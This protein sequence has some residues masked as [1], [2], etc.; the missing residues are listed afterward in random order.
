LIT[1]LIALACFCA[2]S[3]AKEDSTL[4]RLA[5]NVYAHVVSPDGN[6]V[7]NAG[8]LVLEH[9]VLVFDTH[10]TPEAGQALL[11]AIRSI[12]PKPVRY[13][14]N[15]HAHADH[16]HGNQAF[17]DAQLIGSIAARRD[18]MELDLPSMNRTLVIAQRQL[19]A[20]R[21]DLGTEQDPAQTG[22][23]R[24]QIK[25]RED[26][27]QTMSRLKIMPPVVTTG[28][29]IKIIDGRKEVRLLFLGKGHTDGDLV[30]FL[31]A[32]KIAF[33][34]DLFFNDAI[35]NVQD[36][37]ILEWIRTLEGIL[38]LE[39]DQFVPGHG[40]I[41]ARKDV[42]KFQAYFRDLQALVQSAVDRGDT[43]EQA[44]RDLTTP[45]KYSSH[46][47]QN[48]FPSNVQKMY[49]ELKALQLSKM[50]AKPPQKSGMNP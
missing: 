17:A 22:K 1:L 10:F 34:G 35:P 8:V 16:T 42:E 25:V 5:E 21:R 12:T 46:K 14:V 32:E 43:M 18:A 50:P 20:M 29:G 30:L 37:S 2:R 41:G 47:F 26:Y 44:T 7:A 39:A 23:L 28:D 24:E 11:A 19:A 31:P 49:A 13:V 40:P 38:K 4:T 27:L 48:F 36:A 6:A 15:S 45:T 3:S 33:V 9:S